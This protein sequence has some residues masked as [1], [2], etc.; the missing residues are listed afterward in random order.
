MSTH[1]ANRAW[2]YVG[3]VVVVI[4]A[5]VASSSSL[6]SA[7]TLSS[8]EAAKLNPLPQIA[9]PPVAGEV[10][11]GFTSQGWP[12]VLEISKDGTSVSVVRTV[13]SMTCTLGDKFSIGVGEGNLSISPR[14]NILARLQFPPS[15]GSSVSLTGG[16]ERLAGRLDRKHARFSGSWGLHLS[17]AMS[18]GQTDQCDSGRVK[19]H[20]RL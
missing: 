1:V 8:A 14:G 15:P 6:A 5:V 9:P 20:A 2:R 10:L 13:L 12:I 7:R 17:F 19:L 4:L 3:G 18:N 11:G 16:T